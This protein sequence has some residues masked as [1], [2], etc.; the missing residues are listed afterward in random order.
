MPIWSQASVRARRTGLPFWPLWLCGIAVAAALT[1]GAWASPYFPGDVAVARAIQSAD[2][3]AID[4]LF[5]VL[6]PV[7]G[8][9]AMIALTMLSAA[10][11][12]AARRVDLLAVFLVLN[13]LRPVS[14]L[15]KWLS[16]RPRP[17]AALVKVAEYPRDASFP[18]GHVLTSVLVYGGIAVLVEQTSLP[19]M[20]RR[21]VQVVSLSL[22]LLM[23]PARVYVGAHWPSD[24]LGGYVWGAL[25]LVAVMR[26]ASLAGHDGAPGGLHPP[27]QSRC[28]RTRD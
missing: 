15:L 28:P 27:R 19:R 5:G 16:D 8:G 21:A 26:A 13:A 6:N 10:I 24:T 1:L 14:G 22:V 3:P 7:G 17:T 11:L 25:L 12:L 9:I 20:A 4:A 2:R 18:S 23:G